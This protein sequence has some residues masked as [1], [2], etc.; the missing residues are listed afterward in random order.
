M[1]VR[2]DPLASRASRDPLRV[3]GSS[4]RTP[5]SEPLVPLSLQRGGPEVG[6][7]E[8]SLLQLEPKWSRRARRAR[9]SRAPAVRA[10]L[11]LSPPAQSAAPNRAPPGRCAPPPSLTCPSPREARTTPR[12]R[13]PQ[14]ALGRRARVPAPAAIA[15]PDVHPAPLAVPQA[16][17]RR[18]TRLAAG[19]ASPRP[20]TRVD[21]HPPPGAA[22]LP[23]SCLL[24]PRIR[25]NSAHAVEAKAPSSSAHRPARPTATL[26]R[27][28]G[29]GQ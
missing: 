14:H 28:L 15:R 1:R 25:P 26:Q 9:G 13:P 5:R 18:G 11:R 6:A 12:H 20:R 4:E 21:V 17:N 23:P 2:P 7:E 22:P 29:A 10:G 16:Q 27:S 8:R 24:L 3:P 19:L